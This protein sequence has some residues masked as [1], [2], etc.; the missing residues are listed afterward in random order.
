MVGVYT[1]GQRLRELLER[2]RLGAGVVLNG[3]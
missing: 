2:L 3:P 1:G